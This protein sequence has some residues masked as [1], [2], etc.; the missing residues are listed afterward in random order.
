MG[1]R[2]VCRRKAERLGAVR[3]MQELVVWMI[4]LS[5]CV[6]KAGGPSRFDFTLIS[7]ISSLTT[8]KRSRS[9]PGLQAITPG[10]TSVKCEFKTLNLRYLAAEPRPSK[11]CHF[12]LA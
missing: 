10:T 2:G 7:S 3:D 12:Y 9:L 11:Y 8:G 1:V 4:V 6:K 5:S